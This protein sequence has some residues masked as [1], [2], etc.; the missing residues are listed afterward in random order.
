MQITRYVN[1]VPVRSEL[2]SWSQFLEQTGV[3]PSR[4]GELIELGWIEPV[5]TRGELYLFRVRD[6]YRLR[7]MERIC[8]DFDLS[9]VG[10]SIIVDLLERIDALEQKVRQMERLLR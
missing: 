5:R 2:I 4:L 9:S 6:V 8:R 7:K 1:G 10:G 3:H